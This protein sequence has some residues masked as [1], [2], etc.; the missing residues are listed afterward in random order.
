MP[1][2]HQHMLAPSIEL[3]SPPNA[4]HPPAQGAYP[5]RDALHCAV[6]EALERA[7]GWERGRLFVFQG[8]TFSCR[9][10]LGLLCYSYACGVYASADIEASLAEDPVAQEFCAGAFPDWKTLRRFRRLHREALKGCLVDVLAEVEGVASGSP[11]EHFFTEPECSEPPLALW[12]EDLA[13]SS[14]QSEAEERITRAVF[15]D[16]MAMMD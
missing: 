2:L 6:E 14:L 15:M 5:R 1:Y 12:T 8:E 16:G 11:R 3:R 4:L 7:A 10:L 13:P 9:A